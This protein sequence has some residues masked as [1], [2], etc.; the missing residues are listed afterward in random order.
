MIIITGNVEIR[1]MC[2]GD[3]LALSLKHCAQSRQEPG[4][5][6]HDVTSD[7]GNPCKLFFFQR[8]T[9]NAAVQA[10]FALESSQQFVKNLSALCASAPQMEM[11]ESKKLER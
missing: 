9:D 2:L 8:W 10:H 6:S 7:V 1:E 11:F 3:A 4:C 5:I